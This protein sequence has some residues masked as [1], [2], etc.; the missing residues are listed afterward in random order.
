VQK[1]RN[2]MKSIRL[3]FLIISVS[4]SLILLMGLNCEPGPSESRPIVIIDNDDAGFSTVGDNWN[5]STRDPGFYGSSYLWHA[6]GSSKAKAVWYSSLAK[7]GKYNVYTRWVM[8][9]PTDRAKNAPFTIKT[10]KGD[11]TIRVN[12]AE[13]QSA[14]EYPAGQVRSLWNLL[15][16]F[17]FDKDAEIILSNDA[18]NSVVADAVKI[19]Y[20]EPPDAP[21]PKR[22]KLL[23]KDDCETMD[24]WFIEGSEG[25]GEIVNGALH[26][27]STSYQKGVHAW[28]KPDIPDNVIIEYDMTVH[29]PKGFTLVFF[30]AKGANEEDIITGMPVR[31]GIFREYVNNSYMLCYHFSVHRMGREWVE[32]A[33]LNKNPP[34]TLIQRNAVDPCPPSEGD[35]K[36]HI[37]LIKMGSSIRVLVDNKLILFYIDEYSPYNGGKFGFRQIYETTV[38]YDNLRVYNAVLSSQ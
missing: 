27:I 24:N 19:E 30:C 13:I 25:K 3:H 28:F 37:T 26:I 17:I 29:G 18:D 32:G 10:L 5:P 12:L 6:Q 7:P 14:A 11:I 35:Q 2:E 22:E 21:A 20:M 8:S 36:Y 23:F 16:T 9:K 31:D 15:G 4:V 34:K 38:S 33:N 1:W